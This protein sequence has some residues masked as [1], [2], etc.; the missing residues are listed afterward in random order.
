MQ[1]SECYF[2]WLLIVISKSMLVNIY[3]SY[4]IMPVKMDA[5]FLL[6]IRENI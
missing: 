6:V 5:G 1:S 3:W 2:K 4:T